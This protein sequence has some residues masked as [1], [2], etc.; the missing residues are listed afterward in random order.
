MKE[1]LFEE[2]FTS[3]KVFKYESASD[4][5]VKCSDSQGNKMKVKFSVAKVSVS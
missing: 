5:E 2:E 4:L 3:D 1:F